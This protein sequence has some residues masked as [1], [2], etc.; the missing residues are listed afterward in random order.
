[1]R[2]IITSSGGGA[3]GSDAGQDRRPLREL[4]GRGGGRGGRRGPAGRAAGRVDAVT[5]TEELLRLIGGLA[6]RGVGGPRRRR[7]RV[8]PGRPPPLRDVR[9][10]VR[11]G[12]ARRGVLPRGRLRRHPRPPTGATSRPRSR[13][14]ASRT[15]RPGRRGAGA[16]DRHRGRALGQG[17]LPRPAADVQPAD[18]RAFVEPTRPGCRCARSS[19]APASRTPRPP[20]WSWPSRPSSPSVAALLTPDRLPAWRAWAALE[21]HLLALALPVQ[22]VRRRAV[23]L[24]RHRPVR[25]RRRSRSAGSAGSRWWRAPSARPSAGSTSSGTSRPPP[26]SGWTRW[27]PTSSRPT[28]ARSP[29][30]TG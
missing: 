26:R 2:D 27:S 24:L 11:P 20:R 17:A 3:A 18:P 22:R 5:S 6:R 16:G 10:A 8:R 15:P 28:G 13:W 19:T 9:R 30:S 14:P 25:A 4:H 7:G 1:M 21:A 23:P 12:P 29:T